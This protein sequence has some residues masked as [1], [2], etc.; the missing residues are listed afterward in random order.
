[1]QLVSK[2]VPKLKYL[3]SDDQIK[4][5]QELRDEIVILFI[6]EYKCS[7]EEAEKL[8]IIKQIDSIIKELEV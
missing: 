8:Q 3:Y 5:L 6:E 2:F 1:M 7:E 4:S